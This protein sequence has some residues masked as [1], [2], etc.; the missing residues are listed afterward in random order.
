MEKW[1]EDLQAIAQLRDEGLLT[2]EE[3]DAEREKILSA[4]QTSP[5]IRQGSS[6]DRRLKEQPSTLVRESRRPKFWGRR[7]VAGLIL[8]G[9]VVAGSLVLQRRQSGND[10][11]SDVAVEAVLGAFD[12]SI[13]TSIRQAIVFD[14]RSLTSE[15]I[16]STLKIELFDSLSDR[17]AKAIE[18]E[19]A[20]SSRRRLVDS[21]LEE[22]KIPEGSL[23][24]DEISAFKSDP[25]QS[26]T[27]MQ[28][29][30]QIRADSL[31]AIKEFVTGRLLLLSAATG[32]DELALI[33]GY[34][35]NSALL[36]PNVSFADVL[37]VVSPDAIF[38]K[39]SLDKSMLISLAATW[40][41]LSAKSAGLPN[42]FDDLTDGEL[43]KVCT[44]SADSTTPDQSQAANEI[45]NGRLESLERLRRA[46]GAPELMNNAMQA[47]VDASRAGSLSAEFTASQLGNVVAG[48]FFVYEED[49]TRVALTYYSE[50]V[51][52]ESFGEGKLLSRISQEDQRIVRQVAYE[53]GKVLTF[54]LTRGGIASKLVATSFAL[55]G[56]HADFERD[57]VDSLL[58][59]RP[60]EFLALIESPEFAEEKDWR[61]FYDLVKSAF[62]SVDILGPYVD[63]ELKD[64]AEYYGL[65]GPV[66][67]AF[68]NSVIEELRS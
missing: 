5:E 20:D 17:I 61:S 14:S 39:P 29:G 27:L 28:P 55:R 41:S 22:L 62:P 15:K 7:L 1:L 59:D 33:G 18:P 37:L 2:E 21:V 26:L 16:A 46:E 25:L 32:L 35:A 47:V 52:G 53:A 3:F 38:D 64:I 34:R 68:L 23:S 4:R 65:S 48:L 45:V 19:V 6:P 43:E 66:S 60:A 12:L 31:R 30:V 9:I 54:C 36:D 11:G 51:T 8:I 56:F 50:F 40:M 24:D 49:P 13:R 63:N 58:R 67:D 10:L 57:L 42:P 44:L